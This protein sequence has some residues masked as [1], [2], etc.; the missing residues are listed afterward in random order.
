[1]RKLVGMKLGLIVLVWLVQT[2]VFGQTQNDRL[3]QL[4][5]VVISSDSLQEMPYA[6]IYNR[7]V[8]RGTIADMYGFFSLVVQPG[9]TLLFRY[10]G[11][12]PSSYIVPDTL[13]DDRYSIIHMMELDSA[14]FNEVIIYPWPSKEAFAQAFIEMNPYDDALLRAQRQLS[15]Q[16]LAALASKVSSDASISYGNVMNQQN[17]RLYTMGQSPVNNLMN[18]FAWASFLQKWRAGEL[19]R[20]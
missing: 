14:A 19:R 2:C 20:Q 4:S 17:T 15:G 5:G 16:N 6:A 13:K 9:D 7:S 1:M 8:K 11:H 12:K 18:P 10:V 3:V